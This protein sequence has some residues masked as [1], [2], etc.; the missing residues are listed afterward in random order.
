SFIAGHGF[1]NLALIGRID[2]PVLFVHGDADHLIPITMGRRLAEQA[3]ARGEFLVLPGA[4]HNDSYDM[5]GDA[6]VARVQAF[7]T[8]VT[9]P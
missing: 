8:R 1:D 7:I 6:Y 4:G 5:G 2:C 3:G 9:A